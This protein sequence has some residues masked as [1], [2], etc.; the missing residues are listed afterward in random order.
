V[1]LPARLPTM[2]EERGRKIKVYL[3]FS[4][5]DSFY[6]L[7][8]K[9]VFHFHTDIYSVNIA[10]ITESEVYYFMIREYFFPSMRFY[11]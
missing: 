7:G 1:L 8:S 11:I 9:I 2:G 6:Y 3:H 4:S 5:S 10:D